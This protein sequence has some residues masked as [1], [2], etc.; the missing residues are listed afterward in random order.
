MNPNLR[1]DVLHENGHEAIYKEI[2]KWIES[3][4]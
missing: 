4:L 3:R 2:Y 1:H